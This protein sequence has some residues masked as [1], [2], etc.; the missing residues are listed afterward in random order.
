MPASL[1]KLHE[2]KQSLKAECDTLLS[3]DDVSDEDRGRVDA[4]FGEI[5]KIDKDIE[6]AV[7]LAEMPDATDRVARLTDPTDIGTALREAR[8]RDTVP[9]EVRNTT[10]F[11]TF[12]EQLQAIVR[13]GLPGASGAI[14]PRLHAVNQLAVSGAS[15]GVNSDGGFLLQPTFTSELMRRMSELGAI[16]S[17]TRVVPLGLNSNSLKLKTVDE[18]SRV[19][20]SRWG[21][22]RMY[23]AAEGDQATASKPKFG[24]LTLELKKLIGLAYATDELLQDVTALGSVMF[25]AFAEEGVFMAEDAIINGTGAG[26]PMG[27]LNA[28]CTVSQAKESGQTAATINATNLSKM[29]SR[30]W[31]K[32]RP[33]AVWLVNQ[34]CESQFPVMTIGDTPVYLPPGGLSGQ[35]Y[36]TIFGRPVVP[37]EYCATLGTVGDIILADLSQYVRIERSAEQATSVHLRF[38]YDETAFRVTFRLDGQP[39]WRSALTP[40]KGANTLS[41][42]VTLATRA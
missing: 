13:A 25:D 32:C 27:I 12:G 6:R 2:R 14:D 11:R 22:V 40:Y 23:W 41:P 1:R 5:E 34:D 18:S 9:A 21:G 33:N 16:I 10:P 24:E 42:F 29:W 8:G 39:T 38:D 37:V 26:H 35:Q 28:A 15:E 36:G 30:L 19:T 17:R 20:G 3:R 31:A 7:R 4:I